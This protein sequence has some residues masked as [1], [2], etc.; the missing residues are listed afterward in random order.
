[1]PRMHLAIPD[2]WAEDADRM[3]L[4]NTEWARRMIR[5][6]RRQWGFDHVEEPD[7]PHMKMEHSAKDPTRDVEKL[8][9]DAIRR[10]LA[11]EKGIDE[12]ELYELVMGDLEEQFSS[13]LE[14]LLQE[15]EI[16]YSPGKGGLVKR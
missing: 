2:E 4:Q 6:G 7:Y 5:A 13:R 10:N 3:D 11:K 16:D 12:S 14:D 9:E 15:G 1:M 8:L